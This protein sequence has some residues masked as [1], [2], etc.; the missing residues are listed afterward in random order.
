MGAWRHGQPPPRA[1]AARV[2]FRACS[3]GGRV[4]PPAVRFHAVLSPPRRAE[5]EQPHRARNAWTHEVRRANEPT[6]QARLPARAAE[7]PPLYA[8]ASRAATA[9]DSSQCGEAY[10]HCFERLLDGEILGVDR[11][12]GNRAH[13]LCT[14][15]QRRG[16]QILETRRCVSAPDGPA[17]FEAVPARVRRCRQV[18]HDAAQEVTGGTNLIRCAR[19]VEHDWEC[20]PSGCLRQPA[21]RRASLQLTADPLEFR[22]AQSA[23]AG[24]RL[25]RVDCRD[26]RQTPSRKTSGQRRL[27][28][29][30]WAAEDNAELA[31]ATV[32]SR[33]H[34]VTLAPSRAVRDGTKRLDTQ[35]GTNRSR[36][37]SP[38][39]ALC[40]ISAGK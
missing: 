40:S 6:R 21:T 14:K 23:S 7:R 10:E 2:A 24:L 3:A 27:S 32:G 37:P 12:I 39:V 29:A 25:D 4:H 20:G 38:T 34:D 30:E 15:F 31:D 33:P 17:T 36:Q 35:R 19:S 9:G 28:C 26:L 22:S 5:R 16:R 1:R 13:L 11:E 18:D 8:L